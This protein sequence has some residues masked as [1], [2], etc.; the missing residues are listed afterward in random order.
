MPSEKDSPQDN[1]VNRVPESQQGK[2]VS[3]L[4]FKVVDER[5]EA[6][7]NITIKFVQKLAELTS[8]LN[9]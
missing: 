5:Q 7:S 9:Y 8:F 1:G 2:E 3:K 6:S 4:L